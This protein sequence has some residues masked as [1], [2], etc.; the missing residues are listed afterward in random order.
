V[1]RAF[2][3]APQGRLAAIVLLGMLGLAVVAPIL[4]G[5][6]AKMLSV[7]EANQGPSAEHFVGT[8]RLGRDILA[9]ILVATQLSLGLALAATTLGAAIGF[10]FGSVATVL[11][12]PARTASL[13]AIDALQAFPALI[14][15][16]IVAVTMGA[17][18]IAAVVGVGL[19]LSFS[20][21][22]IASALALGIGGRD[23]VTAGRVIGVRS[24]R[25]VTRYVLPNVAETLVITATVAISSSIVS[26]SSLS[27]LGLGVQ[28]PAYDWGRMLTEG[29]QSFYLSP[30]AALAPAAA[31]AITSIAFGFLGDAIARATNPQLWAGSEPDTAERVVTATTPATPST[32][33]MPVV[34]TEDVLTVRDLVVR[35]PGRHGGA[36]VV[37][38][39]SFSIRRREILGIVGESGSGKTMTAMA[40][41]Q[42]VPYPGVVEG[43]VM[44]NGRNLERLDARALHRALGTELAVVFQDPMSSMNPALRV[45]RQ[46]TEGVRAHR[47]VAASTARDLAVQRLR[48]VGMP[49]PE[50]Q[51][52]RHPHELSGGMRQRAMIAMGLMNE[53]LLL[54]ADEPTTALDVTI[55][56]QLMDLLT[57]VSRDRGMAVILISHNIALVSQNCHRVAVMYGGRIVEDGPTDQVVHAPR[58]PYTKA[59]V[60]AVPDLARPRTER[61][62]SI[63]GVAPDPGALPAGCAFHPRC[64][65]AIAVCSTDV[66]VLRSFPGDRRVAC[67]VAERELA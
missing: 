9:R 3:G 8:D 14:V 42:L 53:P 40:L 39:I 27:F 31:I 65:A 1:L 33:A 64:P 28:A 2:F 66:P 29:V 34:S 26:L 67:W 43:S 62:A 63:T 4:L 12:A 47:R 41:T 54:V 46:L 52:Q 32:D 30:A 11:P 37:N 45:G 50:R 25:L 5:E 60:A 18:P 38:R 7:A 24:P 10:A 16:I 58:H 49:A 55:Q 44:L 20:F 15:A 56:A 23:F 35:F 51:L 57:R 59:L 19:A 36:P 6:D 13:R 17:G 22:R 48:E 21:A 61:L